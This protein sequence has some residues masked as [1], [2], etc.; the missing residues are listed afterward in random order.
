MYSR[1]ADFLI[2]PFST[3]N[4]SK[5]NCNSS[6]FGSTLIV[7]NNAEISARDNSPSLSRSRRSNASERSKHYCMWC[8]I[9]KIGVVDNWIIW[10]TST[11]NGLI[12]CV[13]RK[14]RLVST[15][16]GK[17]FTKGVM[18]AKGSKRWKQL[19]DLEN[20]KKRNLPWSF[21]TYRRQM[22]E[23]AMFGNQEVFGYLNDF[24]W[25]VLVD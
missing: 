12:A 5:I 11:S 15:C 20:S 10:F 6:R 2:F 4:S 25:K 9:F 7:R 17:L 24:S 22:N 21:N 18:A 1:K 13:R 16:A 19:D 3:F 23:A 8:S 14:N